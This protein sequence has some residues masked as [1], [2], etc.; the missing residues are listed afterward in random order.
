[1]GVSVGGGTGVTG[2]TGGD[3]GAG[4]IVGERVGTVCRLGLEPGSAHTD[5]NVSATKRIAI[6][7]P[8][9]RN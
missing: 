8:S 3:V 1:M 4:V 9:V 7:A 2:V 6:T 5:T